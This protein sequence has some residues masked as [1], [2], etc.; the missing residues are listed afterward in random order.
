MTGAVTNLASSWKHPIHAR[1][2]RSP[3][4]F[5]SHVR[6]ELTDKQIDRYIA[7]GVYGTEKQAALL[8]QKKRKRK[9][10]VNL[11]KLALKKLLEG[12]HT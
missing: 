4:L 7:Q 8:E 12:V 11:V 2:V 9:R 10:P 3:T 1:G 5:G 6:G